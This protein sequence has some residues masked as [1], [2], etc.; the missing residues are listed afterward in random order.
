MHY[1]ILT[2]IHANIDALEAIVESYERLLVW[3]TWLIMA[4]RPKKRCAG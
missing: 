4:R 3:A 1:L 2:E